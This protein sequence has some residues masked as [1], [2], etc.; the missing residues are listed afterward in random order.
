MMQRGA[1]QVPVAAVLVSAATAVRAADWELL[2]SRTAERRTDRDEI[3]VKAKEGTF[4]AIKLRVRR[5]GV[6][7]KDLRIHFGNGGVHD[8]RVRRFIPAGGETRT[9]DLPGGARVIE[10]VVLYYQSRGRG[11]KRA[12]V[13]LWGMR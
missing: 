10:K 1:R 4:R 11:K 12:L 5:A 3:E 7:L 9:I 6:E 8:V 13:E 2:G